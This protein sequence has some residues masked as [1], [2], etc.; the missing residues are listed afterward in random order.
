M[1]ISY[2][3]IKV[4]SMHNNRSLRN[5][6]LY[7]FLTRVT[8]DH[9]FSEAVNIHYTHQKDC[10]LTRWI[11]VLFTHRYETLCVEMTETRTPFQTSTTCGTPFAFYP[12][13]LIS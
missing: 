3:V 12:G 2:T 5:Y 6:I 8:S 11:I 4:E 13:A 1:T 7:L 9:I 10:Q